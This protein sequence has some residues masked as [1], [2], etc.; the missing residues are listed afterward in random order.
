[1]SDPLKKV[2]PGDKLRMP[3]VA[4]NAFIDT[5][6]A[7]RRRQQSQEQSGTPQLKQSGI[8]LL[9]ND[10]AEDRNRFDVLGISNTV[11]TPT[12]NLDAFKNQ[13]VLAGVKPTPAD[14]AGKFAILLEPVANGKIAQA[15]SA[16]VAIVRINVS[17]ADHAFADVSDN[18][19]GQLQ[20]GESGAAMILWKESGTGV[21]WAVVRIGAGGGSVTSGQYQFMVFQMVAQNQT[22]WDY[23]RAHALI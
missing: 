10:S 18:E 9:R 14:H 5:T 4:Y 12:D 17:D 20:S 8:I 13:I 11:I 7:L 1:M 23:I 21:K 2:Q 15:V 22:G 3:A 19:A 6:M 16:G